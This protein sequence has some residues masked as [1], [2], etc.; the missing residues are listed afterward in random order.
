MTQLALETIRC[1][2]CGDLVILA[3]PCGPVGPRDVCG[4]CIPS[5]RPLD[6]RTTPGAAETHRP[7][8]YGSTA[9]NLVPGRMLE[10]DEPL[11]F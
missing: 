3:E 11:G 9:A 6:P 7:H 10:A 4:D 1:R 5:L 8:D 2:V